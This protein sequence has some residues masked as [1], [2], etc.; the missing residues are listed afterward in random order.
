MCAVVK[1]YRCYPM[2]YSQS[3]L[4][5]SSSQRTALLTAAFRKTYLNCL[6]TKTFSS[7]R[8]FLLL[9]GVALL[10]KHQSAKREATGSNL[11]CTNTEIDFRFCCRKHEKISCLRF[12]VSHV[13]EQAMSLSAFYYCI[14][15]FFL[16]LMQ[17]HPIFVSFVTISAVL[18]RSFN[19]VACRNFALKGLHN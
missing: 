1:F 12:V 16:L 2:Q 9:T 7:C 18:F 13:E 19:N 4:N 5:R 3:S 14:C 8:Q 11:D 15:I 17:F 6:L 10:V